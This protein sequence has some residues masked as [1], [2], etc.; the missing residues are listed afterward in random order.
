MLEY[1]ERSSASV[2][3]AA[4]VVWILVVHDVRVPLRRLQLDCMD[5]RLGRT[6]PKEESDIKT[7]DNDNE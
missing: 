6:F 1:S 4:I 7:G 3:S 5:H 2:E